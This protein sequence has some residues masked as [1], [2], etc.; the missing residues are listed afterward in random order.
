MKRIPLALLIISLLNHFSY[1]KIID[2]LKNREKVKVKVQAIRLNGTVTVDGHLTESVWKKSQSCISEFIQSDPIEGAE[3]TQKTEVMIAYDDRALYIGARMYDTS[4]D[5]IIARL[6]RRDARLNSDE[7]RFYIDPY[8]DRRTGYY[9]AISAAGTLLDGVLL[10]DD[11]SDDTWD[12]VWEGDIQIDN[13]GWTAEMR[14]PYSQLRFHKMDEY[15]WGVNFRRDIQRKNESVYLAYTPKDES[16]FVSRFMDLVG[17]EGIRPTR[18]IEFLP[19]IRTK[20]EFTHPAAGNPF[21]SGSRFLPGIGADIKFGIGNNLT[22]D[23][24]LN[25]DF[26]Q[27]EVDPAVVNLSDIETFYREKRPF[28]I[29]GS[30]IFRFGRGGSSS[31]L[32]LNWPEP[33]LFYSRRIGRAP[34][35]SLPDHDFASVPEGARILGAAKLSGKLNGN[36]NIGVLSA[37]TGRERADLDIGGIRSEVDVEPMTYFGIFRAQKEFN[38]S[39]QALGFMSSIV[40]R[41]FHDPLLRDQFNSGAT[42]FGIDGWSFLDKDKTWV[43]TGWMG[44]SHVQGNTTRLT[45]LQRNSQHYLQRPD[46]DH[47]QVDSSAT[48][49]TGLAGRI[50]LNKQNGN[51]IFNSAIGFVDPWFDVNDAGFMW[52]GDVINAHI[53][54]GYKWVKPGLLTRHAEFHVAHARNYDFGGNNTYAVWFH[55]GY[56]RFLNY[57]TLNYFMAYNPETLNN[58]RTRGG[59]LTLNPDGLQTNWNLSTDSRKPLVFGFGFGTSNYQPNHGWNA[60]VS[61]EWKP[62]SNVSFSL[63]PQYIVDH[64]NAMWIGAFSDP[65]AEKTFG[66]RYVFAELDYREISAGM[67]LN[68]TF[69]PKLSLQL[70]VQPLISVGNYKNYK[71]LSESKTYNFNKYGDGE[72]TFSEET[73]EADP[74]GPS[75]PAEPITLWD[76]DFNFK[77][78]RGNAVLRWEFRPGSVLYFVWTQ[79]RS[80]FENTGTFQ[81]GRSMETLWNTKPDNIFM[82]K[83]TYWWPL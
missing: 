16:G 32:S 12:G 35:G 11:W 27:V 81:F 25:P 75:G 26:G 57:Y 17:I 36:W 64:T 73:Y 55:Y 61:A 78:L 8:C 51:F 48:S 44:L 18:Q 20:A 68:W 69:T 65:L 82:I 37:I 33:D 10:N 21:D 6:G 29:E 24:T 15:R 45:S 34:Q 54:G 4:P 83:A 5:S 77:S 80:D 38:D 46:A 49:M 76:A 39:R 47:V 31:Y 62:S 67:R 53:I 72:S 59:P 42:S 13:E 40:S 22:L 43:V 71:E 52:N 23:A 3:P 2:D 30:S 50:W 14:I 70:Y 63:S 9:F 66:N 74:D 79:R 56:I 58:R 1:A 28:F 60:G 19:Y 41:K 7:F